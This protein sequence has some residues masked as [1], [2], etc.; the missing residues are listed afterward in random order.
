M[1][2]HGASSGRPT[3]PGRESATSGRQG[4]AGRSGSG[5]AATRPPAGFVGCDETIERLY[6][7]LDGELTEQRRVEITRHLDLCG[8]CVG[9]YGFEAE[10]RK[11]IASRCKDHVPDD[12]ITRVA[13]ALQREHTARPTERTAGRRAGRPAD[14]RAVGRS[15]HWS[16]D[17]HRDL[18]ATVGPSRPS[19]RRGGLGHRRAGGRMGREPQPP[20]RPLPARPPPGRLRGATAQAE[21]LVAESTG[22]R[23]SSGPARARV[24]DRAGWVHANVSSFQRCVG[25]HLDRLDPDPAVGRQ[26]GDRAAGRPL[27]TA[28]RVATG[29][30]DGPGA[31]LAVHPGARPVRP[32]AHRG[33]RRGPGPR[34][35]RGAQRG[36]PRAARTASSPASSGCGWPSTR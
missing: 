36:G 13:E 4:S 30:P 22:L 17:R 32:A 12:L 26:P 19:G 11:V 29:H 5:R 34:L 21:E 6:I 20:A 16:R 8:P 24:T 33:R 3:R 28:G 15:L 23:S 31:R 9:A 27:A 25:P 7:Y 10:L 2:A 14:G 18:A 1:E 35:L